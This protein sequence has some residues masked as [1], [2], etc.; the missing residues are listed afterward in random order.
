MPIFKRF[1]LLALV[2]CLLAAT[3]AQAAGKLQLLVTVDWEGR[4]LDPANLQAMQDFRA[5]FPQLPILHYLN[6]AYFTK[7]DADAT[8]AEQ[9]MRGALAPGDEAGLH[10]H[11]WKR[12][13]EAAGVTFRASPQFNTTAPATDCGYDCGHMV[14]ISAYTVE[15]LR[16][17]IRFSN[18][19]LKAHGFGTPRSFRAGGWMAAP[20]VL[21]ALAAE[22]FKTDSS[23]VHA[24]YLESWSAMP[25]YK[26]L[27]QLWPGTDATTQ[28]Y[29]ITTPAGPILEIPDNGC[30]ADYMPAVKQLAA[31]ERAAQAW[32]ADP[33]STRVFVVGFHQETAATYLP[34]FAD[35]LRRISK[36]AKELGVPLSARKLP[37]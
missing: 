25:L 21:H 29:P 22:G 31:F 30:L 3:A 32:L 6:A 8:E 23:A 11:G 7:P 17:V 14:P 2:S 34:S 27:T 35:G 12:L 5:Q 37:L 24:A 20:N 18:A 28:P 10:I 15:E 36:R 9:A 13:F 16:R 1:P 4:N 26:W 33:A 19:T